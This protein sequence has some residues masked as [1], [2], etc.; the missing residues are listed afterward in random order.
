MLQHALACMSEIGIRSDFEL[1]CELSNHKPPAPISETPSVIDK[2]FD[3]SKAHL[4]FP[5]S[6]QRFRDLSSNFHAKT[7]KI[8]RFQ[9][10]NLT[11]SCRTVQIC[12]ES[13]ENL[14]KTHKNLENLRTS[15]PP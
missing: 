5:K 7:A 10:K 3:V 15:L 1:I 8:S 12:G 14:L 6:F 9:G 2:A 13:T 11:D 4:V